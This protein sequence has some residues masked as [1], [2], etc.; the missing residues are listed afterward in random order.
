[1]KRCFWLS[2][3]VIMGTCG[4]CVCKIRTVK[5]NHYDVINPT[6]DLR[7]ESQSIQNSAYPKYGV[8]NSNQKMKYKKRRR[9]ET[10]ELSAFLLNRNMLKVTHSIHRMNRREKKHLFRIF[11]GCGVTESYEWAEE[12]DHLEIKIRLA[13]TVR[14]EDI[15]Y[16]LKS[17]YIYVKLK[18]RTECLLEGKLKGSVD[19]VLSTWFIEKVN[20]YNVLNIH[21]KK[22]KKGVDEWVGVVEKEYVLHLSYDE[23][24]TALK[25][26][27]SSSFLKNA[28]ENEL[29]YSHV[30]ENVEFD[31]VYEFLLNWTS[32][33]ATAGTDFGMPITKLKTS[34]MQNEHGMEIFLSGFDINWKAEDSLVL[35]LSSVKRGIMLHIFRGKVASGILGKHG[36]GI[37]LLVKECEDRILKKL[38]HDIKGVFYL[39]P[40]FEKLEKAMHTQ[41]PEVHYRVAEEGKE[42]TEGDK[43]AYKTRGEETGDNNIREMEQQIQTR[44]NKTMKEKGKEKEKEETEEKGGNERKPKEVEKDSPEEN[45]VVK[46]LNLESKIKLSCDDKSKEPGFMKN[47]SEEKKIE[48]RRNSVLEL[49]RSLE[50]SQEKKVNLKLEDYVNHMK[51]IFDLSDEE[52][53]LMWKKGCKKTEE[54]KERQKFHKFIEIEQLTD[55]IQSYESYGLGEMDEKR[56]QK[57]YTEISHGT[58]T[59]YQISPTI[60]KKHMNSQLLHILDSD[61]AYP[62]DE[63]KQS[64]Y[65]LYRNSSE[66]AKKEMRTKWRVSEMRL[67]T[68]IEELKYIGQDDS[69]VATICNNYRDVLLSEEYICL[70]NLRLYENPPQ[71]IEDKRV[72]QKIHFFVMSLYD[73][74]KILMEHEEKEHLKKIRLICM[75]AI[76]DEKG[77]NEY[78]ESMKP[79]LDYSFLAYIKHAIEIE[80]KNILSQKKDFRKEPSDWLIILLIIK[81]GIYSVLEKDIWEDVIHISS[82]VCHEQPSVR[83]TLLQTL[84]AAM[85]K[86]D[87]IFFKDLI[88]TLYTSV[89]EKKLTVNHFPNFPHI[90]EAIFQLHFDIEQILPD[91]F[92]REM[93]DDY[94]KSV[95]EQMKERKPIFWKMK[96]TQWDKKFVGN[97]RK[98][99]VEKFQEY[100][101]S[102]SISSRKAHDGQMDTP[103]NRKNEEM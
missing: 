88:N 69:I 2:I 79:L 73:D 77:L 51:A 90:I 25:D 86:A 37:R 19:T 49:K 14:T 5:W 27:T 100:I 36:N 74:V 39:N 7:K 11:R 103:G 20:G 24:P 47:W 1:M 3:V 81:K 15:Q 89:L 42:P 102:R 96:E 64:L 80:K 38:Q 12:D 61:L 94:D 97:F 30:F 44:E 67:N 41:N 58:S 93:L 101:S 52:S 6:R 28:R 29:L 72:L 55:R 22:K 70:M 95:I 16:C 17:D 35:K 99:Q 32:K 59:V 10:K 46:E 4:E 50:L 53:Q 18:D 57:G 48:F 75:K 65:E 9:K 54:Q 66:E 45:L 87:W 68:L 78:I 13:E 43:C 34:V 91:W 92:I 8:E 83:K 26:S 40:M 84:V 23:S 82:I 62:V 31:D 63:K 85:S 71:T 33:K 98:K 56:K 76:E 21:L 60:P